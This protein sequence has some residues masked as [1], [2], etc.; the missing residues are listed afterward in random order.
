MC[1]RGGRIYGD[2]VGPGGTHSIQLGTI[3]E[4]KTGKFRVVRTPPPL[5]SVWLMNIFPKNLAVL[6]TI[7]PTQLTFWRESAKEWNLMQLI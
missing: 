3:L 2:T 5:F 7:S 6:P 4:T 1:G